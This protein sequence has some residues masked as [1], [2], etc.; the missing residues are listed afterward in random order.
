MKTIIKVKNLKKHYKR[1]SET[2]KAL[3]GIDFSINSGEIV[4]IVGPSGSGK[5]T[6]L[7]LISCLDNA[8]EGSLF[9]N[10]KNVTNIK[11]KQLIKIRRDNIGFIFQKFYLIS[12][13]TV[14]EN[15]EL[16]LIFAKTEMNFSKTEK[17]IEMVGLKGKTNYAVNMLSGGDKQRVVIARALINEPQIIIA[18]EP[19]GKLETKVRDS[20]MNIFQ[21]LSE[22]GLAV[23][24]A[25]HDLDLAGMAQRIIHLQDGKIIPKKKSDLY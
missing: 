1:G 17:M 25:T 19:T 8:T 16:P 24:I 6:L 12:T 14:K 18:D 13:L 20:I 23:F 9:I 10:E 3:D 22:K 2:V 15:I 11:E 4:S 5:T 7:N 21:K